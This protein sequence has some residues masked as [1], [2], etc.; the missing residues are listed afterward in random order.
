MQSIKENADAN[1]LR[2]SSAHCQLEMRCEMRKGWGGGGGRL[3]DD[4]YEE[5]D[6]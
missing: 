1:A 5:G 4:D 3:S 6:R 2:Y